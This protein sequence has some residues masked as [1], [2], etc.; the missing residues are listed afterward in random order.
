MSNLFRSRID[1]AHKAEEVRFKLEELQSE[2]L[3]DLERGGIGR[4]GRAL[5]AARRSRWDSSPLNLKRRSSESARWHQPLSQTGQC[6]RPDPQL[7][8]A[9]Q[10]TDRSVGLDQDAIR[11]IGLDQ[12]IRGGRL[13]IREHLSCLTYPKYLVRLS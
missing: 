1:E 11:W 5:S 8:H 3:L 6:D 9:K 13:S 12:V 7:F 2:Y 10:V 4:H